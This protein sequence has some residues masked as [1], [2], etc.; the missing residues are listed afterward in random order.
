MTPHEALSFLFG[1]R[2]SKF[3]AA[4]LQRLIRC[5]GVYPP[6]SIVTLSNDTIAMVMSVNP[7]RPLRPWVMVYD[8]NVP[9][10]QA[11]LLDL[12]KEIEINITNAVRPAMLP[13]AIA[14]YLSP[15]KRVIYFFDSSAQPGP[16]GDA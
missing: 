5:L 1:Q 7:A 16:K 12:E 2:R 8:E 11:I 13:P 4:V 9:K 6:G 3:D 14:A 15:R 10:E